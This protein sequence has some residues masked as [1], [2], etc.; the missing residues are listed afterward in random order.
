[1]LLLSDLVFNHSQHRALVSTVNQ[2]CTKDG[3]IL[4][5][6]T[7]H[8]P[9]FAEADM[10]FFRVLCETGWA[11]ERVVEEWTGPMFEEDPGDERVRGTVHGFKAWRI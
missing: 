6:F 11:Y 4:V 2:L 1:L 3:T 7:S 8:R 5:F 9:Q 10:D